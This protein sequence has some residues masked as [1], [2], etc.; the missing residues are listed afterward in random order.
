ML[1]GTLGPQGDLNG[2]FPVGG[3][4]AVAGVQG[5]VYNAEV[6]LRLGPPRAA[7]SNTV[8]FGEPFFALEVIERAV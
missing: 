3:Y 4:G 1:K 6:D 5:D 7:A 8:T 2:L